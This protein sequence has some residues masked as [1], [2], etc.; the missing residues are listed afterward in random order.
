MW[1][2]LCP[3]TKRCYDQYHREHGDSLN[4]Y[5]NDY[6]HITLSLL[7]FLML[8]MSLRDGIIIL[9]RKSIF[10]GRISSETAGRIVA[11][12]GMRVLCGLMYSRGYVRSRQTDRFGNFWRFSHFYIRLHADV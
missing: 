11:T 6:A 2:H 5:E 3:K 12:F 10:C 4:C 9:I 8:E 1:F 7:V